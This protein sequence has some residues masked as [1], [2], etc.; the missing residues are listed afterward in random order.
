MVAQKGRTRYTRWQ[1]QQVKLHYPSCRTTKDKE[2]LAERLGIVDDQGRPSVAKLYN[3]ASRLKV[4]QG[5]DQEERQAA[6]T[7][8]ERLLEREAP[9]DTVFTPQDD[10]Y[11]RS[12]HGRRPTDAIAFARGHTETATLYQ[13]RRLGLRKPVKNWNAVKV[14]R[15]FGMTDEELHALRDEGLDI[16]RL[17]DRKGRLQLEVVSTTS[18][19]RWLENGGRERL[20]G[21]GA[22]QYFLLELDECREHILKNPTDWESC[23]YLSPGHTCNNP[24]AD[25]YGLYC[26]NNERYNAGEDNKCGARMLDLVDLRPDT[27]VF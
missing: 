23:E 8:H 7:D 12:E 21:R 25:S 24:Y 19:W 18:I 1:K 14:A 6:I 9:G 2:E 5:H 26:P 17:H 10:R 27:D 11:I 20:N 4:T 16:Y 15:W 13:A 22:D 3:L